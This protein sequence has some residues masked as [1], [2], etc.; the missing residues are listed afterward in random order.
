MS[1]GRFARP[2]KGAMGHSLS[3]KPKPSSASGKQMLS[4]L[5]LSLFS[6][7]KTSNIPVLPTSDGGPSKLPFKPAAAPKPLGLRSIKPKPASTIGIQNIKKKLGK[8]RPYSI[9]QLLQARQFL[10]T[11]PDNEEEMDGVL[12]EGIGEITGINGFSLVSK[13]SSKTETA[14]PKLKMSNIDALNKQMNSSIAPAKTPATVKTR[15]TPTTSAPRSSPEPVAPQRKPR[16]TFT[17][18]NPAPKPTVN[19]T[20]ADNP[21]GDDVAP[22]QKSQNRWKPGRKRTK[23]E[24]LIGKIKGILNKITFERFDVLS[25]ALIDFISH[26]IK[27]NIQLKKVVSEIFTK[28]VQEQHFGPLYADLC[29][30]LSDMKV[31]DEV[32]EMEVTFK[33]A[34]VTQCQNEFENVFKPQNF[35]DIEDSEERDLKILQAKLR[36]LGTVQFIGQLY[37]KDLLPNKICRVCLINLVATNPT[38]L[39]VE[40][41]YQLLLTIGKKYDSSDRGKTH[42]NTI[43]QHWKSNEG[44]QLRQRTKILMDIIAEVRKNNW[45]PPMKQEKA[46]TLEEIH[47]EF[48]K[49][50]GTIRVAGRQGQATFDEYIS[51]ATS[52][53]SKMLKF[54]LKGGSAIRQISRDSSGQQG[55][56]INLPNFDGFMMD[57]SAIVEDEA[58]FVSPDDDSDEEVAD[59]D[60]VELMPAEER[61]KIKDSFIR[62]FML[63]RVDADKEISTNAQKRFLR[64]V[65]RMG[66]PDKQVLVD[67]ILNFTFDMKAEEALP[68]GEA[69]AKLL[70]CGYIKQKPFIA[71]MT[72][73]CE[74]YTAVEGDAPR[75]NEYFADMMIHVMRAKMLTLSELNELLQKDVNIDKRPR[76]NQPFGRRAEFLAFLLRQEPKLVWEPADFALDPDKIADWRKHYMLDRKK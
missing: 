26:K 10:R 20:G 47:K 18:S 16:T 30:K 8:R 61:E 11:F 53:Y 15:P 25:Q 24:R 56:S 32:N 75:L 35:D 3:S 58:L 31:M 1:G 17:N 70:A 54:R 74:Y 72:D 34:L 39:H 69:L 19:A 52:K 22:L 5:S 21:L 28:T 64:T 51:D 67:K 6:R 42:L 38:D 55:S 71:A 40:A 33:V 41:A 36:A 76:K 66:W 29:C 59:E 48:E 2:E 63:E 73:F 60:L 9:K 50:K 68:L 46:K 62:T 13:D 4:T 49:E 57:S 45:V 37:M 27:T 44:D 14:R 65:K 23:E 12:Q 7:S 43:F